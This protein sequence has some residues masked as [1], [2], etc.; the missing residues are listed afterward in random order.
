MDKA[1]FDLFW[2]AY[3]KKVAKKVA[4]RK[5]LK[6]KSNLFDKIM[7]SLK[8]HKRSRQWRQGFIEHPT[9]WINQE[10]WDDEIVDIDPGILE[11]EHRR[12]T[13]AEK[14]ELKKEAKRL[15]G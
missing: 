8:V 2:E 3:P 12:Q 9:T 10:R 6:L 13:L 7:D 5:F 14:E 1:Q 4:E 11:E 15:L